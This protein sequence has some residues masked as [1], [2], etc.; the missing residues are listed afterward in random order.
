VRVTIDFFL[1]LFPQDLAI[2]HQLPEIRVSS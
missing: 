2:R 1:T